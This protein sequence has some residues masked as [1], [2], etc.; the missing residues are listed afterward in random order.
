MKLETR[1]D[2][3]GT[4]KA[5]IAALEAEYQKLVAPLRSMRGRI[6]GQLYAATIVE[7]EREIVDYKGILEQ[8]G[9]TPSPTLLRK[10]TRR[11]TS[12]EIRISGLRKEDAA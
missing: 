1:I 11:S 10:H 2:K 5:Q 9:V 3:A 7:R 8:L 12:V 4:M 6:P